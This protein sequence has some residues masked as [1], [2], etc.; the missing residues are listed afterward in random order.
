MAL[1]KLRLE[2]DAIDHQIV[3]E[4][5][6]HVV[7]QVGELELARLT[8]STAYLEQWFDELCDGDMAVQ[9]RL[10][11]IVRSQFYN[12]VWDESALARTSLEASL[13]AELLPSAAQRCEVLR[14]RLKELED[15]TR[16]GAQ[17]LLKQRTD[18]AWA[19]AVGDE[20]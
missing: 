7:K 9:E 5:P 6:E 17:A 1:D 12:V 13:V 10:D 16:R 14:H 2:L 3:A 11:H 4:L 19:A 8:R 20:G 15:R 18:A